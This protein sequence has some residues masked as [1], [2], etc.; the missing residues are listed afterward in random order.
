MKGQLHVLN[1]S[2]HTTTKW[3]TDVT[4]GPLDP[5][6]AKAEFDRLVSEGHLAYGTK[7]KDDHEVVHQFD[8]TAYEKI[9]VSPRIAGG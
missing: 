5:A 3:D 1:K 2:G 9:T 4:D 8:P 6:H 7:D